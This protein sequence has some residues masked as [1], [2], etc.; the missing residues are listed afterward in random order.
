MIFFTE[1]GEPQ[2]SF[3]DW[4]TPLCPS[5]YDREESEASEGSILN[6]LVLSSITKLMTRKTRS[7]AGR[8]LHESGTL[9]RA[10]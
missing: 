10:P 1:I 3:T 4:A 9:A 5:G 6:G 2:P 8:F 7:R